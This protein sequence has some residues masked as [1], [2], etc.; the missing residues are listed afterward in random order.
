MISAWVK[1]AHIV[2]KKYSWQFLA[3]KN[4]TKKIVENNLKLNIYTLKCRCT[5]MNKHTYIHNG[6]VPQDTAKPLWLRLQLIK[7]A[8]LQITV[9]YHERNSIQKA[10]GCP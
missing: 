3:K 2:S 10:Y 6:V 5:F 9:V 8:G 7:N 1:I 4:K